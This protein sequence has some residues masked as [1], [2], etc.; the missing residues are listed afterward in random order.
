MDLAAALA[1][2]P[3]DVTLVSYTRTS[4]AGT[5]ARSASCSSAS[6]A[7]RS[8]SR[9]SSAPS[10]GTRLASTPPAS[11]ARRASPSSATP[12]AA[13]LLRAARRYDWRRS[14]ASS[15]RWRRV[16]PASR[17]GTIERLRALTAPIHLEVFASPT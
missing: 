3:S 9:C 5:R 10:G 11:G 17:R 1:D 8:A 13:S 16:A 6:P 14:S 4:R 12:T 2:L 15:A 7:R